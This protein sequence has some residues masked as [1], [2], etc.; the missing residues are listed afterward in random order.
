MHDYSL[1]SAIY[2]LSKL[3]LLQA[4]GGKTL[5]LIRYRKEGYEH[6]RMVT[7]EFPVCQGWDVKL[8]HDQGITPQSGDGLAQ[9]KL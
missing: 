3:S 9:L 8:Q 7:H 2:T 1:F 4:K 6:T 5:D